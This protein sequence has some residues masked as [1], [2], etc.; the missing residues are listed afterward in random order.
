MNRACTSSSGIGIRQ[1]PTALLRYPRWLVDTK[2][3]STNPSTQKIDPV[4]GF[5][6]QPIGVFRI[7]AS[8]S[9]RAPV[10]PRLHNKVIAR[11]LADEFIHRSSSPIIRYACFTVESGV[12]ESRE[13]E[14]P[15]LGVGTRVPMLRLRSR[16]HCAEWAG[17]SL[18]NTHPPPHIALRS[19]Q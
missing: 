8:S 9:A 2:P 18:A 5:V 11:Q 17:L 10:E 16:Q 6:P 14:H 1:V 19:L 7:A 15:T 13:S 4:N 12:A 3:E